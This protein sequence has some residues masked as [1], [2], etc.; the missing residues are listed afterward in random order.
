MPL[1]LPEIEDRLR[2]AVLALL[3]PGESVVWENQNAP[4]PAGK[5]TS[6]F[7]PRFEQDGGEPEDRIGDADDYSGALPVNTVQGYALRVTISCW[8]QD[9]PARAWKLHRLLATETGRAALTPEVVLIDREAVLNL[10]QLNGSQFEP[11][12]QFEA[13]FRV[14]AEDARTETFIE[15]ATVEADPPLS[16]D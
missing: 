1:T 2:A 6:L 16:S 5:F 3:P 4:R 15:T 12:A 9:A 10:P 8:R 7:G 14:T 11:R 13:R